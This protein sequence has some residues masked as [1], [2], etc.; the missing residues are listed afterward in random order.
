MS[1]DLETLQRIHADWVGKKLSIDITRG[2]PSSDMLGIANALDE[3][4]MGDYRSDGIDARNYG[5][6]QGLPA[7]RKW[8]AGHY[9]VPFE[10]VLV[11]G[12]SS[13]EL[14]YQAVL[15]GWQWGY[16]GQPPW[17]EATAAFLCPVPGYDRH[18]A[19]CEHFGIEML[20]VEQDS[21]GP[22]MDAVEALMAG[23]DDIVGMW[24]VPRHGNPSGETYSDEVV[25]RIAALGRSAR[26][27]F[28]VLWDNAYA[29]HDFHPERAPAL[30]NIH[31]V[32]REAGAA[33]SVMMF[34]SLSK[35][36]RASGGVT[37]CAASEG[38]LRELMRTRTVATLGG[39]KVN[40]L[41]HL[42]FFEKHPL[43]EVMRAHGDFLRARFETVNRRLR[44]VSDLCRFSDPSGGYFVSLYVPDGT[45]T[46]VAQLCTEAGLSITPPGAAYPHGNDPADSHLRI[47][48]SYPPIE[49][50][51]TAMQILTNAI[52]LA[53]VQRN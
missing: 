38:N 46:R 29:F 48:P 23:R 21:S 10:N 32:A 13:L 4:D 16:A 35:V 34:S 49:D 22:D 31:D 14:M 19:I 47:A 51:D 2:K 30:L 1:Q 17:R 18:F 26:A 43:E 3:T 11:G 28:R 24:C 27:D 7:M 9:G 36:T 40:Q 42:K 45:A 37:F 12:N 6:P 41:R 50:L 5:E 33:D 44:E 39:D 20:P 8:L 25:R 15:R 52:R 53:H